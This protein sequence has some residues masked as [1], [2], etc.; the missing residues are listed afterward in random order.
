[1]DPLLRSVLLPLRSQE[2]P[3]LLQESRKSGLVLKDQVI[4]AGERHES[5]AR[6]TPGKP[7]TL[8]EGHA[9]VVARMHD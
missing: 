5:R 9:G 4:A 6:N 8:V 2:R 7:P 1:M 3:H